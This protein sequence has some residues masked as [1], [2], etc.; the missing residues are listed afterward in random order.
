MYYLNKVLL[1]IIAMS[2]LVM[3][4]QRYKSAHDHFSNKGSTSTIALTVIV[5]VFVIFIAWIYIK[6]KMEDKYK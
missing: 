4:N 5:A 2:N 6:K 3:A 1:L